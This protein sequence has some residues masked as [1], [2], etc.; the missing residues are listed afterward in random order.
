MISV[1]T[2]TQIAFAYGEIAAAEKLLADAKQAIDR[3]EPTDPRDV[4]GRR[5]RGCQLGIPSG[6]NSHRLLNVPFS[7]AVPIIEAHIA[8]C[9]AKI[10]ALTEKAKS[11]IELA[12]TGG[13]QS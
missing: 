1:E 11:E 13:E 4:F 10:A 12:K 8:G 5:Q 2:A 7:L 6:E 9:R 3:D